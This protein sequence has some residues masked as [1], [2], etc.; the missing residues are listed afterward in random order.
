LTEQAI[1]PVTSDALDGHRV[2]QGGP[3]VGRPHRLSTN[4]DLARPAL[5]TALRTGFVKDL[6][7][8]TFAA[9]RQLRSERRRK[10]G[11]TLGAPGRGL[12]NLLAVAPDQANARR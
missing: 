5:F 1:M 2:A 4:P 8:R 12:G 7:Q 9:T 6:L 3:S 11:L 10:V